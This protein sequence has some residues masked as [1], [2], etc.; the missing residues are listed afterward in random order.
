MYEHRTSVVVALSLFSS[1]LGC[2]FTVSEAQLLGTEMQVNATET[3]DQR[4]PSVGGGTDAGF[5]VVWSTSDLDGSGYGVFGRR[6]D[7][8]GVPRRGDFQINTRTIGDQTDPVV[9]VDADGDFIVV[10]QSYDPSTLRWQVFGRRFDRDGA[11]RGDEFEVGSREPNRRMWPSIATRDTGEFVV[12]WQQP[13][14]GAEGI[15]GRRFDADGTAIGNDFRVN[16]SIEGNQVEPEIAMDGSGNFVVAWT[17]NA[18]GRYD[19]FARRFDA[20]G[21]PIEA[22]FRVNTNTLEYQFGPAIDMDRSGSFV[23]AWHS[24]DGQDGSSYGVFG[25]RFE[26]DGAPAGS[27]FRVNSYTPGVQANPEVTIGPAGDFV[28]IWDSEGQDGSQLGVFAQRYDRDGQPLGEEFRV[29][30]SIS[31]DQYGPASAGD[32]RGNIFV[33]W[34]SYGQDTPESYGVFGRRLRIAIFDGSFE[35]GSPCDWSLVTA[36]GQTCP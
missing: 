24:S 18:E 16:S 29:N 35:S 25:Q 31:G 5:V 19:V 14:G 33:A 10:W 13:D 22:G 17:S 2:P 27:E 28:V 32:G 1:Q 30:R 7:R 15:F 4:G 3:G 23:V 20:D 36:G 9:A 8:S 6:V 21:R 34:S 26:A 11:P 12:V